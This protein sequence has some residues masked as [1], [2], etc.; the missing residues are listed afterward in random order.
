MFQLLLPHNINVSSRDKDG[1]SP[2]MWACRLDH[3]DHFELLCKANQWQNDEE[4]EIDDSG[5]TWLHWA[6][7]RTEPLECLQVKHS[8]APD[9]PLANL[10]FCPPN[11]YL[12]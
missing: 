4:V 5:R 6:V 3:I 1:L 11:F 8:S 9:S 12:K 7:R 2:S 10:T